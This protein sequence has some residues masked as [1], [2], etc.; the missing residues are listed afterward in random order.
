MLERVVDGKIGFVNIIYPRAL[1]LIVQRIEHLSILPYGVSAQEQEV[2]LLNL[3]EFIMESSLDNIVE[4]LIYLWF[5]QRLFEIFGEARLAELAARFIHLEE[6]SQRLEELEK[7]LKLK[8][9]RLRHELTDRSMREL[10]A[11]RSLYGTK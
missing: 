1:S 7:K 9:F 4:Y 5:G 2:R 10:F 6:S 8:Y 11:A 3:N